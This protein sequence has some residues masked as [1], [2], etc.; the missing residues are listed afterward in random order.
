MIGEIESNVQMERQPLDRGKA[1]L[2][3]HTGGKA[4]SEGTYVSRKQKYG[5]SLQKF[6]SD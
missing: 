4:V 6:I 1:T 5:L 2:S 3:L